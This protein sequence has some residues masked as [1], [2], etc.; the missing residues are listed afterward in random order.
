MCSMGPNKQRDDRDNNG[1]VQGISAGLNASVPSL[2]YEK[3]V[4]NKKEPADSMINIEKV[5]DIIQSL[6]GLKI[7]AETAR[8]AYD[9]E[10]AIQHYTLALELAKK[11]PG[12]ITSQTEFDLFAGRETCYGLL[13]LYREQQADLDVM[14]QLAVEMN[15]VPRQIQVVTS[16][17]TGWRPRPRSGLF[18]FV[19]CNIQLT[20]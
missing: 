20:G 19:G 5:D 7:S 11:H 4:I 15:D 2:Q 16:Q 13:G 10:A 18:N 3:P 1:E 14:K 8:Q 12:T 6:D 17:V 9:N